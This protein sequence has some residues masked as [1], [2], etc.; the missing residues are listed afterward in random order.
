MNSANSE[1]T[2]STRKIQKAQWPRR[3]A[4]KLCQRRRLS[5]ESAN[6]CRSGGTPSPIGVCAVVSGTLMVVRSSSSH[7]P[8][9]EID[10][11]INPRIREI[12][13]EVHHEPDQR[14]D[15]KRGE[16]HRVIAIEHALEA[17]QAD[18]VEGKNGLDEQRAGEEGVHKG[19]REARDHDQH[20]VAEHVPVE[21]L[22]LAAALGAGGEHVLLANLVEE[23]VL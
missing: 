6:R 5:G 4:L 20:G 14:H 12:R 11:R 7:L 15:V 13:E 22:P 3:L 10:A 21:H 17:E 9:L 2:N 23:R 18:A 19:A 8:R 1:M 16:N